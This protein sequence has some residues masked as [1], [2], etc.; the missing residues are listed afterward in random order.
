MCNP[1]RALPRQRVVDL[2]LCPSSWKWAVDLRPT[3]CC[4]TSPRTNPS[5]LRAWPAAGARRRGQNSAILPALPRQRVVD[6][7]LASMPVVLEACSGFA[8]CPLHAV[9]QSC[10]C[11]GKAFQPLVLVDLLGAVRPSS[12]RTALVDLLVEELK[13]VSH[14]TAPLHETVLACGSVPYR[15][16]TGSGQGVLVLL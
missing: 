12:R 11:M 3:R 6:L 7:H 1:A 2:H 9:G 8:Y 15:G 10:F 5:D 14:P 16:P 4:W 13:P